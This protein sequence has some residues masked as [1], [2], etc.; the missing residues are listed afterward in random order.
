MLHSNLAKG[1]SLKCCCC[2][3]CTEQF[4]PELFGSVRTFGR[5]THN[6]VIGGLDLKMSKACLKLS[7]DNLCPAALIKMSPSW[8]CPDSHAGWDG[9]ILLTRIKFVNG[10]GASGPPERKKIKIIYLTITK[11]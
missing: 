11:T 4:E 2:C 1:F 6:V 3:F 10:G 5:H 8:N 7:P 9:N